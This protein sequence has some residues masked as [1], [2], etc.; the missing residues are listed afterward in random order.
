MIF[1]PEEAEQEVED[2]G[3]EFGEVLILPPAF[4]PVPPVERDIKEGLPLPATTE[5]V[6]EEME[7]DEPKGITGQR[8]Q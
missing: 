7:D 8:Q 5:E 4:D 6:P 1:Q 2:N 3:D